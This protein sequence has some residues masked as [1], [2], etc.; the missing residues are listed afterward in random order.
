MLLL[1]NLLKQLRHMHQNPSP[2]RKYC[3]DIPESDSIVI[4]DYILSLEADYSYRGQRYHW[5]I[6]A[7]VN[8][9][10]MVCWGHAPT[11]RLA[12]LAARSEVA[13]LEFALVEASL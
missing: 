11:R 2:R 8:P 10:E 12:E 6:C 13:K 9:E 4:G 3:P 7:T 5:M 1:R